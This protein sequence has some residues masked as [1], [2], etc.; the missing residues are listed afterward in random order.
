MIK[1]DLSLAVGD[2]FKRENTASA[3]ECKD[4]KCEDPTC[5]NKIH[6]YHIPIAGVGGALPIWF[7]LKI[8]VG[9]F[10]ISYIRLKVGPYKH[11]LK[12]MYDLLV[13]EIEKPPYPVPKG[14]DTG[15]CLCSCKRP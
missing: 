12:Q 13:V 5:G 9:S 8:G 15:A 1:G 10:P 11:F 7:F 3:E 4:T 2:G 6:V 14:R